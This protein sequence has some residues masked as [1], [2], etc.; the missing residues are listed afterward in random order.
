MKATFTRRY[1]RMVSNLGRDTL[2]LEIQ[3]R[4]CKGKI[5][6]EV[7]KL[8]SLLDNTTTPQAK[9]KLLPT[10]SSHLS[11]HER[12]VYIHH[13]ST[14]R[15]WQN[16]MVPLGVMKQLSICLH[17]KMLSHPSIR[18]PTLLQTW[19]ENY[20]AS[21]SSTFHLSM[22]CCQTKQPPCTITFCK[23]Q[24]MLPRKWPSPSSFFF[25]TLKEALFV[26]LHFNFQEHAT[27]VA[28]T[29]SH[30]QYGKL[31]KITCYWWLWHSYQSERSPFTIL[32]W[33][34]R[35]PAHSFSWIVFWATLRIPGW[36]VITFSS[37]GSVFEQDGNRTHKITWRDGAGSSTILYFLWFNTVCH[38]LTTSHHL[39]AGRCYH[40]RASPNWSCTCPTWCWIT[41]TQANWKYIA[42]RPAFEPF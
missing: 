19:Q 37:N 27:K 12:R 23:G 33:S 36:V 29:I 32:N 18:F 14:V 3:N 9:H 35:S 5:Q 22:L 2:L 41:V 11:G 6:L 34:N 40:R 20:F 39:P 25:R 4:F 17:S 31:S 16:C 10:L 26:L 24:R 38:Q 7:V 21:L 8:L 1:E 30:R 13:K 42:A 28:S 15:R